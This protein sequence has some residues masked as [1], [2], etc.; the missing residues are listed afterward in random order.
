MTG[1]D[2]KFTKQISTLAI[3]LILSSCTTR[4]VKRLDILSE[5]YE[6]GSY[7]EVITSVKTVEKSYGKQAELLYNA[8]LGSLFHYA[9]Q[10]DSSNFYL[11]KAFTVFDDLF[12]KSITNEAASL[13]TNDN[14][15]PYRSKPYEMIYLHQLAALNYMALGKPDEALVESRRTQL[16]IDEWTK[17]DKRDTRLTDDAGF[18]FMT[19]LAYGQQNDVGNGSVSLFKAVESAKDAGITVP[20]SLENLSYCTFD[21][22]GRT[23]DIDSLKLESSVKCDSV[24]PLEPSNKSA[25]IV[26]VG[27]L[28]RGPVLTDEVWWGTWAKGGALI[29][30]H[31]VGDRDEAVAIDA[32]YVPGAESGTFTLKFAQPKVQKFTPL[33][34][35][36]SCSIGNQPPQRGEQFTDFNQ[37]A[38][39]WDADNA[40]KDLLRTVIRVATR[41][42]AAEKAKAQMATGN[43]MLDLLVNIGTDAAAAQL[44]QADTRTLFLVPQQIQIVRLKTEPGDQIVSVE[45]DGSHQIRNIPVNGLKAGERRWVTVSELR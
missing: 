26:V 6:K 45:L 13:V 22:I 37:L 25:E 30:Y 33:V 9:G 14:V 18:Q 11:E 31:R 7:P 17:K 34:L 39:R 43:G 35:G 21:K 2:M 8:D 42:I 20:Q 38:D 12:T 24:L 28:G 32:P 10:Y 16:L 3:L 1:L 23:S 5:S 19:A 44:E 15:R 40:N 29:L 27:L 4:A 36:M 41:T